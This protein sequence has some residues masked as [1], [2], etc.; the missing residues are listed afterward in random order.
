MT[1]A[2]SRLSGLEESVVLL[3]ASI[4]REEREVMAR[5][6]SAETLRHDIERAE[7]HMRVVTDDTERLDLERRE[8]EES[9]AKALSEAATAEETRRGTKER[10][11]QTTAVLADLGVASADREELAPIEAA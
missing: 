4:A 9:R 2:K 7:R 8:L 10:I 5:E 1:D 3:N 11:E 6:M